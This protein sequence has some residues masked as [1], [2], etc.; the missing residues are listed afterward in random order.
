MIEK[1]TVLPELDVES[2]QEGHTQTDVCREIIDQ[3]MSINSLTKEKINQMKV[4]VARGRGA[5]SIVKNSELIGRLRTHEIPKL[6]PLLTRKPTR[7]A[8]G[9]IVIAVMTEP[10]P[11]P[12][13]SPC[14]YCPGGPSLGVPQSYT[15]FEPATMRG[16]QHGFD[17][18][19][20]VR[21]RIDQLRK[22]GHMVDKVEIVIMGGTFPST[23]SKYQE[24]FVKGCLDG[25]IGFRTTSFQRSKELVGNAEIHNSG[26]TVETRPDWCR[27]KDVDQ[28]LQY[29]VTRVEVGVQNVYDTI[30]EMV[31]RGH[32]VKDVVDATRLLKDSGLKVLYHL[33]PGLPGSNFEMDL[34]GFKRVIL[35]PDFKPDMIKIYPCLVVKGTKIYDWW[36]QGTYRPYS[37]E[38]ATHLIAEMKKLVPPWIRIMRVQRDIPAHLIEAGVKKSNLRQLVHERLR[39]E[40][41]T[42][43]CIRCREAGHKFLKEGIVPNQQKIRITHAEEEASEGTD[44]FFSAEDVDSD[45]LVG[46]L[47]LRIPSAKDRRPEIL[48]DQTAIVR[49]L[50]VY[51][52]L[53]P[54]GVHLK[55]A[56]QHKGYGARLLSE[57]ERLVNEDYDRKKLLVLSALGTKGYYRRFGYENEG[58][59]MSKML[60]VQLT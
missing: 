2:P 58:P 15:G 29:G 60:N 54:V 56:W 23:P 11:C 24:Q 7:V 16:I 53:V 52:V 3:L 34:E 9:V 51:G 41:A 5:R 30:Y 39:A 44:L 35:N 49:E 43:H 26:L 18:Y 4:I 55:E 37:T 47:R 27:E 46:C 38:E 59:Y 28:M 31:N 32:K 33:M 1:T 14:S 22:I 45:I 17:S 19:T 57:A 36:K 25:L 48:T 50:R 6:L 8:S 21:A 13:Q 12:V 40:D 20:Q 10:W 42:C